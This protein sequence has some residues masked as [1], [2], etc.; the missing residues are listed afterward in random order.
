M[1]SS[2]ETARAAPP[3][4]ALL[5]R[6]QQQ[7]QRQILG[8]LLHDLR[9]P[10][11][12]IRITMELFGRLARHRTD[13][14]QGNQDK[15]LERAAAYIEPAEAALHNLLV[16][17]ERLG[18]YLAGPAAPVMAPLA[19]P[20]WLA[21]ISLLL[22]ASTRR[23]RV[24]LAPIESTQGWLVQADRA[25][26]SHAL[27]RYC[28]SRDSSQ[29]SLAARADGSDFIHIDVGFGAAEASSAQPGNGEAV[30]SAEP[31]LTMEELR[32]LIEN[33]GGTL[34]PGASVSLRFQRSAAL[35]P[36]GR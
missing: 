15:L 8:K 26:A 17:N 2:P 32:V 4:A 11:H 16:T 34:A 3:D 31:Q 10:I 14:D 23:L 24:E 9:N 29:V 19:I 22:R 5:R 1:K 12:C 36:S 33:A 18:L 25:R 6:V 30:D 28:L 27:L 35:S 13:Q 21:E 20:E 7:N